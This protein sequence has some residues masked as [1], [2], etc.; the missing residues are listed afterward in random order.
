VNEKVEG[1][2]LNLAIHVPTGKGNLEKKQKTYQKRNRGALARQSQWD[3]CRNH[4]DPSDDAVSSERHHGE[5]HH[6]TWA[7]GKYYAKKK[8]KGHE[9]LHKGKGGVNPEKQREK[10]IQLGGRTKLL[11]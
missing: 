8:E 9:M 6:S 3:I 11:F 2:R 4:H 1:R 5:V 7:E 10:L